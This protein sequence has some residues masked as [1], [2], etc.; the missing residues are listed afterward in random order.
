MWDIVRLPLF[1][2]I[3]VGALCGLSGVFGVLRRRVFFAESIT[4]STFPGAVLGVVIAGM[5]TCLLY[6][7]PSPRD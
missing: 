4:H 6:T 7:S 2:I 1:E 3:V 5:F